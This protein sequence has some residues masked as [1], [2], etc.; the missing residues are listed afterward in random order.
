MTILRVRFIFWLLRRVVRAE[1]IQ[2]A[3]WTAEIPGQQWR[4]TIER[5]PSAESAKRCVHCNSGQGY[6]DEYE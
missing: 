2:A 4:L 5:D 6:E 1:C 3:T